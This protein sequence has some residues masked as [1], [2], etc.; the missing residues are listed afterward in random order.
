MGLILVDTEEKVATFYTCMSDVAEVLKVDRSTVYRWAK[1]GEK[2]KI[3][4]WS[5][6]LYFDCE[7]VR[8]K[9]KKGGKFNAGKFR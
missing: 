1:S 9:N 7:I 4:D 2:V 5:Q 8:S 3:T 6:Y